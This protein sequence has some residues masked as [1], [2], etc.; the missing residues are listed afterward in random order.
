MTD[1]SENPEYTLYLE[2]VD[3]RRIQWDFGKVNLTG[4]RETEESPSRGN[5]GHRQ[6]KP[7]ISRALKRYST[8]AWSILQADCHRTKKRAFSWLLSR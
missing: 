5:V 4:L 7:I 8:R 6:A 2:A 3:A 1:P